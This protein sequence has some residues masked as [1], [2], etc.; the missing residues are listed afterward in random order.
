MGWEWL[1]ESGW[2]ATT[3]RRAGPEPTNKLDHPGDCEVLR[4]SPAIHRFVEDLTL[5]PDLT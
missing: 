2:S 5:K 3:G 4:V 1:S